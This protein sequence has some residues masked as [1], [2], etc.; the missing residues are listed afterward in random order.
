MA[1]PRAPEQY[2]ALIRSRLQ[3][4][5]ATREGILRQ[6]D[7]IAEIAAVIVAA[8]RQ[9]KKL[10]LFGNGGSAA[11]AQHIAA[12]LVGKYYLDRPSLPA[13]ALTVNTSSL[14]AISNDYAFS[15]V[16]ARQ[17]EALGQPGDV[18]LAISTSGNSENVI[19]GIAA[20][21]EK[22]LVTVGLTGQDG[23][24]LK[25]VVDYCIRIP[26][27]DTPRIQESHILV[28]HI[29]CEIAERELFGQPGEGR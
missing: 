10:L 6:L 11:D 14:T 28:G 3:E 22:G 1:N 29:L 25:D 17:V 26:S 5:L 19:Q 20:A 9:G 2:K 15:R 12:E 4:S 24:R 21:K 7:Q 13:A 18:A 16:F 8:Y 23:G 27:R